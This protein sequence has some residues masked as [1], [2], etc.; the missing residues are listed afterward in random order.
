VAGSLGAPNASGGNMDARVRERLSS[1]HTADD[2]RSSG[3]RGG[4][5]GVPKFVGK[6]YGLAGEG[7]EGCRTQVGLGVDSDQLRGLDQGV[8]DRGDLLAPHDGTTHATFQSVVPHGS[9]SG[10][11]LRVKRVPLRQG[12][13]NAA[14]TV[15]SRDD[16]LGGSAGRRPCMETIVEKRAV[17]IAAGAIA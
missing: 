14:R 8:E 10:L 7:G 9:G 2:E 13:L 4:C 11:S 15:A 6:R 17:S 16:A 12:S 3:C 1:T 5:D